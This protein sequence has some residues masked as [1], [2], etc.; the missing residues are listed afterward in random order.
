MICDVMLGAC[1]SSYELV[2]V[3]LSLRRP[4]LF[5]RLLDD[6]LHPQVLALLHLAHDLDDVEERILKPHVLFA[7]MLKIRV[8]TDRVEHRLAELHFAAEDE[9]RVVRIL[10]RD[11]VDVVLDLHDLRLGVL[12]VERGLDKIAVFLRRTDVELHVAFAAHD[13]EAEKCLE[14]AEKMRL[15]PRNRR[16]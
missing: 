12:C 13:L 16:L 6:D 5:V 11:A 14:L 15:L 4:V 3:L 8:R 9:V 1:F 7:K 10:V 2:E